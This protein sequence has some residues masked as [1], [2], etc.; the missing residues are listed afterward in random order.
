MSAKVSNLLEDL[1][2]L[3]YPK[4]CMACSKTLVT[5]EECICT[6]CRY[7]L[8]RTNYHLE[9][10]NPVAKLF[11]GRVDIRSAAA[12]YLFTKGGHIQ[13]LVH[14]LKYEGQKKVGIEVGRMYGS[15]LKRSEMF[16]SA[17]VIV[18]VPLHPAKLRDRGY[19]QCDLFADGLAQSLSVP[20]D[21]GNLHRAVATGSQTRRSRF[22]R[23]KNVE[24]VFKMHNPQHLQGK[25]IL[26]VDDVVTTGA[27]LEACAQELLSIPGTSVSIAAIAFTSS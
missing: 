27:T 21:T 22:D 20:A 4:V 1:I 10:D 17:E 26:L 12:F 6:H 2:S 16:S 7:H 14:R 25:H 18:P 19:N 15:E 24:Y 8:P 5:N 9:H 3:V 23:W 13:Q 11:W